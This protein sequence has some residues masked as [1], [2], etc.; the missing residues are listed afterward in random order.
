MKPYQVV[1]SIVWNTNIST[2][3]SSVVKV[4][5]VAA[6]QSTEVGQVIN[7]GVAPWIIF[8]LNEETFPELAALL[9][10]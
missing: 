10:V 3:L 6:T 7:L 4:G 5:A 8:K 9:N 1:P 2:A